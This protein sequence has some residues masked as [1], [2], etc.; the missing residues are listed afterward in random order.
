MLDG[1]V[2]IA[3]LSIEIHIYVWKL[4]SSGSRRKDIVGLVILEREET[5][6][7]MI[8][9]SFILLLIYVLAIK[10]PIPNKSMEHLFENVYIVASSAQ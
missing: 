3:L 9:L 6:S 2:F 4:S 10:S 7:Y 1:T 5:S 8:D